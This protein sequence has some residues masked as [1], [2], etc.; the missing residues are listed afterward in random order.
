[1]T[2]NIVMYL[3]NQ[4]N[5]QSIIPSTDVIQLTLTLNMTTTQVVE[6]SVT[7]N[8]NSPFRTTFTRMIKHNLLLKFFFGRIYLHWKLLTIDRPLHL[9]ILPLSMERIIATILIDKKNTFSYFVQ[10]LLG[11]IFPSAA[12]KIVLSQT[13]FVKT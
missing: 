11:E 4:I 5:N 8:N 3:T 6:T 13:K 7:V 12:S 2:N 9:T 1:M 10:F